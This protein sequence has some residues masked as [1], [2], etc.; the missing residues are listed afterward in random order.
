V[1]GPDAAELAL[2]VRLLRPNRVHSITAPISRRARHLMEALPPP[3]PLT[4]GDAL[5]AA[6]A[7][8]HSLPLYTL[9]PGRFAP[10]SG[11]TAIRPY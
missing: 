5:V 1:R 4:A 10:G 6:T 9:D 3:A 7:I 11:L 2:L 8:E